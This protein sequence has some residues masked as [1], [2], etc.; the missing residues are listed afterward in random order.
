MLALASHRSP[1]PALA[2][3]AGIGLRAEHGAEFL[4]REPDVGFIEVHAENYFG[5]GGLPRH[6]LRQARRNHALSLH[7][8]GLSIGSTDPI[9]AAHLQRL[10]ELVE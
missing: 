1:H 2:L 5:R 6:L 9:D 4:E 8:V 7:G 10:A 3:R